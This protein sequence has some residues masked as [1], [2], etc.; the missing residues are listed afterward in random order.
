MPDRY[1]CEVVYVERLCD[2]I[3]SVIIACDE[4]AGNAQAGQ[5]I[6]IKCGNERLLRRP[7]SI[8]SVG[9]HSLE[10][11]FEVKG[12]GTRWLSLLQP[13]DILDV[14]GPLGNGFSFPE[15]NIIVVGGGIGVPPMLFAAQS[16]RSGVTAVLGFR[17]SERIILKKDFE[18]ACDEV[19]LATDD[20]S[21]G[22]PGPVTPHLEKLILN[23]KY[24]AVFACGNHLMLLAV[25]ELCL[26]NNIACQVSLEEKMGCGVG[27]CLVC[28]C[29]VS[30]EGRADMRRVCVD[31]PVFAASDID[32]KAV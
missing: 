10:F 7:I 23:G 22:V 32:W 4:L 25:S 6:H 3:F 28:A 9:S 11:V 14:I 30:I 5:F 8:C 26:R 31:G 1:F 29:A 12:E 27:A 24:D 18:S 15:G 16:A 13:G 17:N 19:Y 21:N 20:G 2:C